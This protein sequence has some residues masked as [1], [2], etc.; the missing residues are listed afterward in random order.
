MLV[1]PRVLCFFKQKTAYEI[2]TR[3]WSSDVC[4]SDLRPSP[5]PSARPSGPASAPAS[6][7]LAASSS[8]GSSLLLAFAR[9]DEL[10]AEVLLQGL[11][12]GIFADGGL[13]LGGFRSLL[14]D[15]DLDFRAEQL[16]RDLVEERLGIAHALAGEGVL[17]RNAQDVV[18]QR[19]G[20]VGE[21]GGGAG[22]GFLHTIEE[23]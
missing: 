6:A 20:S 13:L 7:G 12:H 9:L 15:G 23:C 21:K 8:S 3:D 1:R 4:S 5:P 14:F 22:P 11:E 18:A 10:G 2:S 16:A 19:D 17:K